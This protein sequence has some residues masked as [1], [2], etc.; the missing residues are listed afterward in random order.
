MIRILVMMLLDKN[1]GKY[2]NN[3]RV[4]RLMIQSIKIADAD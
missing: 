3:Q 2:L 4:N 1:R